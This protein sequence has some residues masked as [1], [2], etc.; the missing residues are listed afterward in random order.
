MTRWPTR[1]ESQ[2]WPTSSTWVTTAMAIMPP[3]SRVRSSVFFSGIASSRT[4]RSRKGEIMP[5]PA[6]TT[7]S[8][9]TASSWRR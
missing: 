9:M 8:A 7:I 1:L 6:E 5:R 2:V 3:T 4:S